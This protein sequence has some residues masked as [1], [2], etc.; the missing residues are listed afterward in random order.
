MAKI[1]KIFQITFNGI[2]VTQSNVGGKDFFKL[3]IKMSYLIKVTLKQ[4]NTKNVPNFKIYNNIK[5]FH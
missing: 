5:S 1:L 3:K 2:S 4:Q